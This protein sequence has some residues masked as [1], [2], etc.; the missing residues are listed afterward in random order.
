MAATFN[1]LRGRD[2]IWNYVVNNY[3]LGEEPAPFDLLHWNSRHHQPAGE[4]GTATIS[5]R[6][7]R[8]TSW[9]KRRDQGRRSRRSTCRKVEDSRLYP[10]GPRGSYRAARERVEDH[11]PFRRPE[12]LRARRIGPHRRGGQSAGRAEISILDQRSAGGDARK[13][14]STAPT[15]HKGSWWPDWVEWLKS[16][17]AEDGRGQRRANSGQGQ[18]EGDR[19]RAGPLCPSR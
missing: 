19:G 11:G 9:S 3:L 10:G 6:S 18:A 5:T 1:L 12:A 2:L 16:R 15:E 13:P 14:S 4:A 8:G 17:D 7:T